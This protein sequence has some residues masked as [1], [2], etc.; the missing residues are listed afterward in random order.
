MAK[1]S[2]FV[3]EKDPIR[4]PYTQ[5]VIEDEFQNNYAKSLKVIQADITKILTDK[6]DGK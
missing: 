5:K 4:N 6:K 3:K 1:D 2:R